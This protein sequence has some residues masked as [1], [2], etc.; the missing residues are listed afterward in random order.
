M[1]SI[2]AMAGAV[3]LACLLVTGQF[4]AWGQIG[5]RSG[6]SGASGL[7]PRITDSPATPGVGSGTGS[8][9]GSGATPGST[10]PASGGAFVPSD[11]TA[12]S[13]G[14]APGATPPPLRAPGS[15]LDPAA[16]GNAATPEAGSG[17]RFG[18]PPSTTPPAASTPPTL[19]DP[20]FAPSDGLPPRD[21]LAPGDPLSQRDPLL[22]G[23]D[24]IDDSG[25]RP[26]PGAEG[27]FDREGAMPPNPIR[28]ARPNDLPSPRETDLDQTGVGGAPKAI[29]RNHLATFYLASD[30]GTGHYRLQHGQSAPVLPCVDGQCQPGA[31][32]VP[33]LAG[34]RFDVESTDPNYWHYIPSEGDEFTAEWAFA[35][36]PSRNGAFAVYRQTRQSPGW[37]RYGSFSRHVFQVPV[38]R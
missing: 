14:T 22:P 27:G 7:R 32:M 3:A 31:N 30:V 1:R 35:K 20:L 2:L 16:P 15:T 34:L 38:A 9:V 5:G 29:Y 33:H 28:G 11:P 24:P 10:G 18:L 21:P 6:D 4:A 26:L 19:E 36:Q 12:P 17:L 8:R 13:G 25:A 23:T 37:A